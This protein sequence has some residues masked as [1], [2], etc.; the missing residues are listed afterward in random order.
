[1]FFAPGI[2][3]F[4]RLSSGM[5]GTLD[6]FYLIMLTISAIANVLIIQFIL[7]LKRRICK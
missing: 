2:L 4:T 7:S 1:M 5:L 3:I 6:N